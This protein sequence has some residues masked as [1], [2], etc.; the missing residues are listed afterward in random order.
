MIDG[1]ARFI[2]AAVHAADA[3]I[4]TERQGETMPLNVSLWPSAPRH[5]H[6]HL[7]VHSELLPNQ[8]RAPRLISRRSPRLVD[9]YIISMPRFA[10]AA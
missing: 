8:P 6:F 4:A 5:R 10:R 7:H 9:R 2:A 3:A 1:F